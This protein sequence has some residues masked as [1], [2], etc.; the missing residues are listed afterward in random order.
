M[1]KHH[2]AVGCP[3]NIAVNQSANIFNTSSYFNSIHCQESLNK[4]ITLPEMLAGIF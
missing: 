4:S 3:G 2:P 1:P